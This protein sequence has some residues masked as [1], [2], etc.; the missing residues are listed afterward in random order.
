MSAD[1]KDD[2]TRRDFLYIATGAAG[3]VIGA[4]AIWPLVAQL[5]PNARE[6]AAGAPVTVDVSSI[7][8]GEF[9]KILWRGSSYFIRHLT[10]EEVAQAHSV[11]KE[12]Y[13]DFASAETRLSGPSGSSPVWAIYAANCTHLGC[14]PTQVSKGFDQWSC[15][16][17]GSRFDA[18]GRVTKG[19]APTNLPQPPFVF[20]S[21]EQV[22]IGTTDQ[23]GA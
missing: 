18:L 2:A 21:N 19:P 9:V 3:A 22:V 4:G 11:A 23:S 13:R 20:A 6:I 7:E 16:C 8:A 10:S 14:I 17:H 5:A 15:P 12:D 1:H